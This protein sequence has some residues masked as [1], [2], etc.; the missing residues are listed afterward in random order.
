[1]EDYKKSKKFVSNVI[2]ELLRGKD[3]QLVRVMTRHENHRRRLERKIT[4]LQEDVT[5]AQDEEHRTKEECD[6]YDKTILVLNRA[7][8]THLS[9]R[10]IGKEISHETLRR[11]DAAATLAH[12]RIAQHHKEVDELRRKLRT[13]EL[14]LQ[15]RANNEDTLQANVST[16]RH[17]LEMLL[18]RAE[19][20][21][22]M[23]GA[24]AVEQLIQDA[25]QDLSQVKELQGDPK[26]LRLAQDRQK[27]MAEMSKVKKEMDRLMTEKK[28]MEQALRKAEQDVVQMRLR[29]MERDSAMAMA[30]KRVKAFEL[31]LE[32]EANSA[33]KRVAE[34]ERHAV[35]VAKRF[36]ERLAEANR[37]LEDREKQLAERQ[38]MVDHFRAQAT[39]E[40]SKLVK[41]KKELEIAAAVV[42]TELRTELDKAKRRGVNL[43]SELTATTRTLEA[44]VK[45]FETQMA[46]TMAEG[47]TA[48]QQLQEALANLKQAQEAASQQEAQVQALAEQLQSLSLKKLRQDAEIEKAR[49]VIGDLTVERDAQMARLEEVA[50]QTLEMNQQLTVSGED[51]DKRR[52]DRRVTAREETIASTTGKRGRAKSLAMSTSTVD[53][54]SPSDDELQ[55]NSRSEAMAT[56]TDDMGST[57][58]SPKKTDKLTPKSTK[59]KN[60]AAAT[61]STSPLS[62]SNA[63]SFSPSHPSVGSI[64]A[65]LP[66]APKLSPRS[67]KVLR[68]NTV[69]N[70]AVGIGA[71]PVPAAMA[72]AFEALQKKIAQ[73]TEW[74]AYDARAQH[75]AI[76]KRI[77]LALK[78]LVGGIAQIASRRIPAAAAAAGG[79][80][81][82]RASVTSSTAALPPTLSPGINSKDAK[83]KSGVTTTKS[84]SKS[85]GGVTATS[86]RQRIGS[87][88]LA[89]VSAVSSESDN[90]DERDVDG[91]AP[92]QQLQAQHPNRTVGGRRSFQTPWWPRHPPSLRQRQRPRLQQPER[93][94]APRRRT[95]S[96]QQLPPQSP[97]TAA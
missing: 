91:D 69:L 88:S 22:E 7:L 5:H 87:T 13:A 40:K 32:E 82:P 35:E 44:R 62:D 33:S 28:T 76:A 51:K 86:T 68:H 93:P 81:G 66:V 26:L 78:E 8:L 3:M 46:S 21:M 96:P 31:K 15:A 77:D 89:E 42:E 25:A 85:K 95:C 17:A 65:M 2:S 53:V 60:D 90:G 41:V 34:A 27:E 74:R 61:S 70:D 72:V 30:G 39:E 48:S 57:L 64:S 67:E 14:E 18:A 50:L 4:D 63:S 20:V 58:R 71:N 75:I 47:E 45:D 49:A 79:G 56:E 92:T 59:A 37:N 10:E 12:N 38:K 94:T 43:E 73:I 97:L 1:M 83:T 55:P 24:Q 16:L 11:K 29:L 23:K 36:E 80:A 19:N 52:S 84:S 6:E 9:D 54:R